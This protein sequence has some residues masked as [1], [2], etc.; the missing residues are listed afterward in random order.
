M[1][2]DLD[3][4][5]L[6]CVTAFALLMVGCGQ[7][8]AVYQSSPDA[9]SWRVQKRSPLVATRPLAASPEFIVPSDV[10]RILKMKCYLCH[11]GAETNGGFDFKKMIYQQSPNAEWQPMDWRGAT[12]IKLAILPVNGR[13]ARMPRKAGSTWNRLTQ[14]EANTV[15]AWTD[16]PFSR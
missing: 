11:G 7:P 8:D 12:R 14:E 6:V 15:A 3:R 10:S 5:Q 16:Y 2:F 13:P 9:N 4:C 1:R